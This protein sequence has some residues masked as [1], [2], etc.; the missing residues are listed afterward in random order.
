M[1]CCRVTVYLLAMHF[2]VTVTSHLAVTIDISTSLAALVSQPSFAVIKIKEMQ[3]FRVLVVVWWFLIHYFI[4][5]Y[6]EKWLRYRKDRSTNIVKY[7]GLRLNFFFLGLFY[8]I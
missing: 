7:R 4:S 8:T 2:I 6:D 5:N 1:Q 3:W